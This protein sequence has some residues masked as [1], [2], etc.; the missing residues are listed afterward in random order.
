MTVLIAMATFALV[1]SIT[2]GP[3][4]IVGLGA[5]ASHGFRAS[6]RHVF[7]AT[8]GFVLLLLLVGMGLREV[9]VA[10]PL[11]VNVVQWAGVLFL[12]YVAWKLA[13]D[14]GRLSM[15]G[16][17]SPPSIMVGAAMQWLNPKAWLAAVSGVALFV[18]DGELT[19]MVQFAAIYFVV[20]YLSLACWAYAGAFLRRFLS[21]ARGVRLFNRSMALLLIGC[22]ASLMLH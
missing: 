4:N 9:L 21:N 14:H 13:S 17:D 2:P 8:L 18:A 12:L 16:N 11:L 1:A 20:C 10:M 19:L 3:V 7:G 6:Q 15:D 22:S 5:G